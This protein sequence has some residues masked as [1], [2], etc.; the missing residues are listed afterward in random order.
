M[1]ITMFPRIAQVPVAWPVA[2]TLL[3]AIAC[4]QP[5]Y[6]SPAPA[7]PDATV[8]GFLSAVRDKDID[9]MAALWGTSSGP[10]ANRMDSQTLEQRLTITRIYLEH[11]EYTIVPRPADVVVDLESGE[12]AVFVRLTRKGCTPVVPFILTPYAG[13]WL[14]RNVDLE[15]AGNPARTCHP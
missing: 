12:Q 2:G 9:R 15:M 7:D 13:G 11:E 14:V 10:A 5:S 6:N 3:I 1:N 8:I 4:S